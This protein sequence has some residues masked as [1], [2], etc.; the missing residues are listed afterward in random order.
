MTLISPKFS[1]SPLSLTL[2]L[3]SLVLTHRYFPLRFDMLRGRDVEGASK[4]RVRVYERTRDEDSI[5][6]EYDGA[7]NTS[8]G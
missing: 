7:E 1:L 8:G 4:V 2:Y 6:E 3:P 5:D